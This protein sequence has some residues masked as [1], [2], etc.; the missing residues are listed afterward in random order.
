MTARK[1][2]FSDLGNTIIFSHRHTIGERV[3]VE[4]LDGR[5]QS[6]M[7]KRGYAL[8]QNIERGSFIPVTTRTLAQYGRISF[9]DDGSIPYYALLDNGGILPVDGKT[10]SKWLD[11]TMK[12]TE[13]DRLLMEDIVIKFSSYAEIKWQDN[14]ALF[15]KADDGTGESIAAAAA[16][17]GL[18]AFRHMNKI[19]IFPNCLSKGSSVRRFLKRYPFGYFVAAGD[20]EV[21]V[22]MMT[23]A[24]EAY[25]PLQMKN[26]AD[27]NG[28]IKFVEA[29]EIAEYIFRP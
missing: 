20:S 22:S 8:L 23:E 14:L 21:D 26:A 12:M 9:F 16:D 2:I 27:K 29:A 25:M 7:T 28:R 6:Y 1:A 24:D 15:V 13:N 11:E 3:P 4:R 18:T 5:E 10:D 17:I 19:Y